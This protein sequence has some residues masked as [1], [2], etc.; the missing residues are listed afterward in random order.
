MK[1]IFEGKLSYKSCFY[2]L[3]WALNFEI[4]IEY[5]L[6]IKDIYFGNAAAGCFTVFFC[7]GTEEVEGGQERKVMP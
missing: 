2:F 6:Q 7:Q 3:N 1:G 4:C 5:I